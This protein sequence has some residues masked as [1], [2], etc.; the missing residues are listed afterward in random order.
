M[1]LFILVLLVIYLSTLCFV[2][3]F[4]K[5]FLIDKTINGKSFYKAHN[6][7]FNDR[8]YVEGHFE[9][10][11]YFNFLKSHLQSTLLIDETLIDKIRGIDLLY[12]EATFKKDLV[13]RAKETGHSTTLE[14]ATIANKAV[15]KN[16]LIG[17]FSQRYR[18]LDEL[19]AESKDT[20]KNTLLSKSGLELDFNKLS[21]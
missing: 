13:D 21:S 4:N 3:I 5:I 6:H 17:H 18:N 16:L 1:I 9:T 8:L 12:H 19:L 11:N 14:A 15:V 20:F 10:E 7:P 2:S